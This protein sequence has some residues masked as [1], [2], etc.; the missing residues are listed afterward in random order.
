MDIT[1][2]TETL[3]A[4]DN[5][6]NDFD[7]Q[8]DSESTAFTIKN[9][10]ILP[11]ILYTV[12]TWYPNPSPSITNYNVYPIFNSELGLI[13]MVSTS[14]LLAFGWMFLF[15][16]PKRFPVWFDDIVL[17]RRWSKCLSVLVNRHFK[18]VLTNLYFVGYLMHAGFT[19]TMVILGTRFPENMAW[20]A[21][22]FLYCF[23]ANAMIHVVNESGITPQ[24]KYIVFL[25]SYLALYVQLAI[26]WIARGPLFW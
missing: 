18:S 16:K 21:L 9:I 22:S 7:S 6:S 11:I 1:H 3:V 8:P 13:H 26:E 25:S 24:Y 17:P 12:I 15:M 2:P 14:V 23:N 19:L 10:W 5:P 20:L 4:N